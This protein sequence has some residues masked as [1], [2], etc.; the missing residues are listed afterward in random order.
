MLVHVTSYQ[1][2][3]VRCVIDT[4]EPVRAAWDQVHHGP[5]PHHR[6]RRH[7]RHRRIAGRQLQPAP[8]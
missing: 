5:L 8:A 2:E 1:K 6:S 7:H 4:T 3:Q